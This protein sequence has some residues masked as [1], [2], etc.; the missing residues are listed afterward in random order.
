MSE[1]DKARAARWFA[2]HKNHVERIANFKKAIE[3][4]SASYEPFGSDAGRPEL[5]TGAHWRWFLNEGLP[6]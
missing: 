5:W 6:Q 4:A 2:E 1:Q 3:T